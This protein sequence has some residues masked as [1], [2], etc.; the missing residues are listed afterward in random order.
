MRKQFGHVQHMEDSSRVKQALHW[1][2]MK[3]E[4]DSTLHLDDTFRRDVKHT[5]MTQE[6]VRLVEMDRD[7]WKNWTA[8]CASYWKDK[9]IIMYS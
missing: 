8:G 1:S 4:T 7:E 5:D 6:D 3:E 2:L 9:G